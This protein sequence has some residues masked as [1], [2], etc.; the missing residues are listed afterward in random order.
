M[1]A[2]K[3]GLDV[4]TNGIVRGDDPTVL[5]I[6]P[7]AKLDQPR[8]VE[9]VDEFIDNSAVMIDVDAVLNQFRIGKFCRALA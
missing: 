9:Y 5:F 7:K 8:L 1:E 6:D 3:I 2:I 4:I